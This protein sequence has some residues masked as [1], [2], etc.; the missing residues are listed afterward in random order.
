MQTRDYFNS[1]EEQLEFIK[2]AQNGN[3]IAQM[4]I[5]R[6]YK[7]LLCKLIKIY[8]NSYSNCAY[9][10]DDYISEC[11]I[12]VL[13]CIADYLPHQVFSMKLEWAIRDRLKVLIDKGDGI[14]RL[15][16]LSS[17]K[18]IALR[19]GKML[20]KSLDEPIRRLDGN[21]LTRGECLDPKRI[22]NFLGSSMDHDSDARQENE[23][24]Q[25]YVLNKCISN[26]QKHKQEILRDYYG[27]NGTPKKLRELA[28]IHGV[29]IE[30]IRQIKEE[31]LAELKKKYSKE[32]LEVYCS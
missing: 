9:T 5:I 8:L 23:S 18:G 32:L 6:A 24:Y 17:K 7:G 15:P 3:E 19:G 27:L 14:S 30:R 22:I 31:A 1:K 10:F 13:K 26:L 16:S 11:Q 29:S 25:C 4:R 20:I 2:E 28:E 21:F 12:V